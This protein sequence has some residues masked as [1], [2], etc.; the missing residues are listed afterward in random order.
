M[1]QII[2][3][4]FL[5]RSSQFA[6]TVAESLKVELNLIT[7]KLTKMEKLKHWYTIKYKNKIVY[8]ILFIRSLKIGAK[9]Q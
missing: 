6:M 7:N 3:D 5:L 8:N 4:C 2:L 9:H 1:L